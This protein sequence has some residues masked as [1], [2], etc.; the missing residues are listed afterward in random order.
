MRLSTSAPRSRD[1]PAGISASYSSSRA[2][3]DARAA[4]GVDD[5][6]ARFREDVHVTLRGRVA[7]NR[8]AAELNVHRDA[9]FD[10]ASAG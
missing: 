8:F 2:A 4:A 1:G 7:L 9:V 6:H 5:V 10:F 3:A